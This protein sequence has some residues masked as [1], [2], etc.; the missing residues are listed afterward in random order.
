MILY[1]LVDDDTG[2][3]S[4]PSHI[5]VNQLP[6]LARKLKPFVEIMSFEPAKYHDPK[7]LISN[8]R[9]KKK[10]KQDETK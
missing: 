8:K 9:K 7:A 2:V 1:Q 10:K 6:K 3:A 4:C 5:S